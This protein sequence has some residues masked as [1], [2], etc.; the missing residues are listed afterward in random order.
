MAL[1]SE[2]FRTAS[3]ILDR[4]DSS[5]ANI[6]LFINVSE[7]KIM[8]L[9]LGDLVGDLQSRS[10]EAIENAEEFIYIG[11][12]VDETERDIKLRKGHTWAHGHLFID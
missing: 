7:T 10:V 11:S 8:T 2:D 6:G 1:L 12:W 3:E 9:N 5:A 4:V